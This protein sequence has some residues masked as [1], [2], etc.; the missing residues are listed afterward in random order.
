MVNDLMEVDGA[1]PID[2]RL[3]GSEAQGSGW[4]WHHPA[5]GLAATPVPTFAVLLAGLALGSQ[6]LGVLTPAVLRAVAPVIAVATVVLGLLIGLGA[7]TVPRSGAMGLGAAAV[8]EAG[9]TVGIVTAVFIGVGHL[10]EWEWAGGAYLPILIGI[11]AIASAARTRAGRQASMPARVGDLDDLLTI[12][13][14]AVLLAYAER[15]SISS[16]LVTFGLTT[17]LT[18]MLALAAWLLL[19]GASGDGEHRVYATGSI[20]LLTGLAASFSAST[21]FAGALAAVVWSLS[22]SHGRE[23]LAR[24]LRYLQHPVVVLVLVIAGAGASTSLPIVALAGVLALVRLGAKAIGGALAA[25]LVPGS[26]RRLGLTLVAPGVAGIASVLM[27]GQTM[28]LGSGLDNLLGI[29]VWGAIVSDLLARLA[30]PDE[31]HA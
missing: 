3:G 6:G 14:G 16:G 12:L 29:V 21:L 28:G 8:I 20:L 5:L 23:P 27:A 26:D 4:A 25:P 11:A 15:A 17:V 13:A 22:A 31:G 7:T 30:S 2:S 24:D 10:P 9:V 18:C 1:D 19:S